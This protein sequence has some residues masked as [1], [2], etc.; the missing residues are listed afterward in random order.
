MILPLDV[1][2]L[3]DAFTANPQ[4]IG[5]GLYNPTSGVIRLGSFD[6]QT[7][8]KGDDGL[9]EVLGV[10]DHEEWRGYLPIRWDFPSYKPFQSRRWD[11]DNE[12]G[13]CVPGLRGA[14]TGWTTCLNGG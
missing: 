4:D 7:Q 8:G 9:A 5:V 10:T 2:E 12:T 6:R 3:Q 11:V 14:E 1:A 13:L